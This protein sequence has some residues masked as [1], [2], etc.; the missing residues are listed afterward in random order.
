MIKKKIKQKITKNTLILEIA[1]RY[2][3]L[4]DILVEKYGLHCLGCSFSAVESL[5]EGAMGHGM[6]KKEIEKMVIELNSEASKVELKRKK[7][8]DK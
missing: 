6:N 4:V 8:S 2:P 1:E 5:E 7:K 3:K